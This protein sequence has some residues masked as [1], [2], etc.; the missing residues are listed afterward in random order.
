M[1]SDCVSKH[2]VNNN[3]S[4]NMFLKHIILFTEPNESPNKIIFVSWKSDYSHL[5]QGPAGRFTLHRHHHMLWEQQ[6]REENEQTGVHYRYAGIPLKIL[7]RW[8]I[9]A[10]TNTGLAQVK[11][12]RERVC[13]FFFAACVG[14]Q[15]GQDFCSLAGLQ[16]DPIQWKILQW[17]RNYLLNTFNTDV[18]PFSA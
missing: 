2:H 5:N 12:C 17:L 14:R 4:K 15:R 11:T 18:L 7:S 10:Y 3:F 1:R 16:H 8:P 13:V 6:F 9:H